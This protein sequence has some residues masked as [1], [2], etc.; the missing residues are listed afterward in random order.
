M[1]MVHEESELDLDVKALI[2]DYP[3]NLTNDP[4][5]GLP[6][7]HIVYAIALQYEGQTVHR[8]MHR[9]SHSCTDRLTFASGPGPGPVRELDCSPTGRTGTS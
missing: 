7:G 4:P 6:K 5:V 8:N 3:K 2:H 1:V 9:L